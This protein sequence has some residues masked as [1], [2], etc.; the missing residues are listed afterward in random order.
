MK[1]TIKNQKENNEQRKAIEHKNGPLLIVAGAGTGKTFTLTERIINLIRNGVPPEQILAVTFTNKAAKEMKERVFNGLNIK[2]DGVRHHSLAPSFANDGVQQ[3]EP[4]ISTFHSLGVYLIKENHQKL[5]LNKNFK[6]LD[7][8]ESISLIKEAMKD[9]GLDPKEIE[10]RKIKSIISRKKNDLVDMEELGK[11]RNPNE[12][13]AF[14]VSKRYEELKNKEKALDFDDLLLKSFLLLKNNED[15]KNY[16]QNKWQYLHIDEYQDTNAI[17]YELTKMLASQHKNICVVGDSDQNIYSWRGANIQ[18]ILNFETDYPDAQIIKLEENYRSTQNIL[19]VA[20]EIISKNNFRKEKNL[21]TKNPEGEKIFFGETENEYGEAILIAEKIKELLISG[22]KENDI[23]ILFRTNFQ[24]RILEEICLQEDIKYQLLGT[25][26][27]ERKEIKD[28]LA[29]INAALNKE[30]LSDIKRIIDFP[31]RGIG[32]VT[33]LKMFAGKI[34]ELPAKTIAKINQ[35]YDLL[36]KIKDFAE[37]NKPSEIIKFI[38][39]ETGIA[40][41]LKE[42]NEEEIEKLANIYELINVA[43][44]Y[45]MM[46]IPEGLEKLLEDTA[47]MSDQD[48]LIDKKNQNGVKLMTIHAAKGLEFPYV[49]ITGLEQGL[50]PHDREVFHNPEDEEEERR[51]FYVALTRAKKK[52]FLTYAKN[53]TVFGTTRNN[54]PSEFIYDIP[55]ELIERNNN[56]FFEIIL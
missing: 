27:Y 47:L 49:F 46:T 41:K 55:Q 1:V 9:N 25:K 45:D 54:Y 7:E 53:R 28:I 32:K 2:S 12:R 30:S 4:L 20:N 10:P 36:S 39:K 56:K 31:A 38:L 40:K 22:K 29:Y 24:S 6:I 16:Y 8:N 23:A 5:N 26:F 13:V 37:N 21:F 3:K 11:S 35:F 51:L 44:K 18:N 14:L 15:L 33:L 19:T 34:N 17:Q 50:F 42:G 52:L 43:T 48:H